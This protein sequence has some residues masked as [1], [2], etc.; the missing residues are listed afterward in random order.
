M[1]IT[2]IIL[3][4]LLIFGFG[5]YTW[6]VRRT[7]KRSRKLYS[8]LPGRIGVI[9]EREEILY[10]NTESEMETDLSRIKVLRDIPNIDYPKLS[11]A[12]RMVFS[13][14][15]KN[16]LDYEYKS[17]KRIMSLAPLSSDLFGQKALVWFS[18]DN[19]ELQMARLQ[20]EEYA[21]KLKKTTRLWDIL[22]NALP[23]HIFAKDPDHD[24][25]YIFN[26]RTRAEFF[27]ISIDEL[28]GKN[29][30]DFLPADIAK[31]MRISDEKNM[32]DL[33]AFETDSAKF[34]DA[35]GN[36]HIMKIIQIPFVDDD[37][38]R[39]LLG[40]A[41]DTTELVK[42]K[43]QAEENAEWFKR[44]LQSIGD[45]VITTDAKGGIVL[46]NPV[47]ERMLGVKQK[48][49]IHHSH[50]E[51]FKIVSAYDDLPMQSPLL[52]TLRT[53]NIVELANHTDLI[54][55]DGNRYHI[56]DSAAPILD[57]ERNI[58]GAILVFRDVTEEYENRDRLRDMLKM[59]E[60]GSDLTKS[61]AFS[62]NFTTRKITGAK[63]LKDLWPIND[64]EIVDSIRNWVYEPDQ[65][66]MENVINDLKTG[67]QDNA[68]VDYRA[69]KDNQIHYYQT[70]MSTERS[71]SNEIN[72][73]GVIQD[74]TE[75]TVNMQK[76]AESVEF[77]EMAISTLPIMFFVKDIDNEFRYIICNEA[78]AKFHNLT[79]K[80]IIGKKD[81]ELGRICTDDIYKDD[82]QVASSREVFQFNYTVEDKSGFSHKLEN[83]K[84]SFVQASGKRIIVGAS[85][86]IT[87]LQ[88]VIQ[89]EG[90]IKDVLANII[91]EP[92]FRGAFGRL[93]SSL[94]SILNCSRI[95]LAKCNKEG[96]L[97]FNTEWHLPQLTDM[98]S[99]SQEKH[100]KV[101]N[102]YINLIQHGE[103]VKFSD[104]RSSDFCEKYHLF[105]NCDAIPKSLIIA[106]VSIEKKLWG[107]LFVSFSE[108]K[109]AFSSSDESLMRSMADIIALAQIRALQQQEI[110][111]ANHERQMILDHIHI[112]VWLHDSRGELVLANS[113]VLKIAGVS[114]EQLT[115][116]M[117]KNIFCSEIP[118]DLPRPVPTVLKT[119]KECCLRMPFHKREYMVSAQPIFDNNKIAYIVKSAIDITELNQSL[120]SQQLVNFCMETFFAQ[121]N[122]KLAFTLVLNEICR[123]LGAERCFVM[124]FDSATNIASTIAEYYQED[125]TKMWSDL[126]NFHY[127]NTEPWFDSFLQNEFISWSNTHQ[128]G[129]EE[130]FGCWYPIISKLPSLHVLGIYLDGKFWGDIGI[131]FS[132]PDH[133]LSER[134]KVL[135]KTIRGIFELFLERMVAQDKIISSMKK[136]EAADKAKSFFIASISHEIRTPL[137][138][139]IGFTELLRDT[140]L[141]PEERTE[142]L[143]GVLYSG[144]ALLQ[145]INDVLDLSK[146][147]A[148]QMEIITEPT[149]FYELGKEIFHTFSLSAKENHVE[150]EMQI[151]NLPQLQLDKMRV[152]QI[153][154]NLVGN[155]VKFTC[156]GIVTLTAVFLPDDDKSGTLKFSVID[157][158]IGIDLKDQKKLMQPFVQLSKM[159]GTNASNNGTGL[160][161]P[162]CKRL[163]E[164]MNGTLEIQSVINKGSIFTTTLHHV[165]Y[166]YNTVVATEVVA[167]QTP[168]LSTYDS[169]SLLLVDDVQMNLKVMVSMF[170]KIGVHDICY[171]TS[172]KEALALLKTRKFN[173]VLTDLWMPVMTGDELERAIHQIPEYSSLPVVVVTADIE[174]KVTQ[175]NDCLFKP[176][177]ME[178]CRMILSKY[179][180]IQTLT[181]VQ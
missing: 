67:K 29:D 53:G 35:A 39:M 69:V 68:I 172:G 41:F 131:T 70:K 11:E 5:G 147:E 22:I 17:V 121:S 44:T 99:E 95:I 89:N 94:N 127:C 115:T 76:H 173:L 108:K 93:A 14:G 146:L 159:R 151:Q 10:L 150:L 51:I 111:K 118:V 169:L 78:F 119:G 160:G 15:K 66:K 102:E 55:G 85:T 84:K 50:D 123:Y 25:R 80:Q 158:G 18:H 88:N 181:E 161:L 112:P 3:F 162:I 59:L 34:R 31:K 137:N 38:S 180:P 153:L 128:A 96:L 36:L 163:I 138:A 60:Y 72:L 61:A 71:H 167:A 109:R 20:A 45:G 4:L 149:D 73:I 133:Q 157:T 91:L 19:S 141:S 144:K 117:N 152:R 56:A 77:W 64:D 103:L 26:N 86:D 179:C 7:L 110:R 58:I 143:E 154:F 107:A 165:Q 176:V 47:A 90:V 174:S 92:T 113:E 164:K 30:F 125:H 130:F 114:M 81:S 175:F 9:N 126:K 63:N 139:V 156:K 65:Q 87:S 166:T 54:A 83:V 140:T 148:D 23:I 28:N 142:Y 116:E 134:E 120:K 101:W 98:S 2:N 155:A 16:T 8:A 132:A 145:L 33:E 104:F 37:G 1:I 57:H 129:A 62:L 12:A 177:T 49:V 75:I 43:Q 13:S 106:P 24:F 124:K 27:G 48:D 100:Q 105:T 42:S 52:R 74:I 97:R 170:R 46:L 171:A 178:K 82:L 40:T 6:T 32:K 21:T 135:I 122:M 79:M 168:S 136:A